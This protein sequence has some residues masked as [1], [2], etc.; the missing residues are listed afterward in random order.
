M[1]KN[2]YFFFFVSISFCVVLM[3]F[4]GCPKPA[5]SPDEKPD[6]TVIKADDEGDAEMAPC[7]IA[8]PCP[9][10]SAEVESIPSDDPRI[11]EALVIDSR[12]T[13]SYEKWH[14]PDA[15]NIVFDILDSPPAEVVEGVIE[16]NA[17]LVV[18]YG[19]GDDPD[20]GEELARDL[21]GMGVKNVY[22]IEG[23]YSALQAP[24]E[25]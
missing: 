3:L 19:D 16:R 8:A 9:E 10:A 20:S 2:S 4:S 25:E 24:V 14:Y 21:A 23:G 22:F 12:D 17:E 5:D 13:G 6:L 11:K 18:V 1:N 7:T 15:I